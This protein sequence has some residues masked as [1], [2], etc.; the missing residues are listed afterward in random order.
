MN[1]EDGDHH[2][3]ERV[4]SARRCAVAAD[5]DPPAPALTHETVYTPLP[6]DQW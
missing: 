5:L 1:W 2:R 6:C 4:R 3:E